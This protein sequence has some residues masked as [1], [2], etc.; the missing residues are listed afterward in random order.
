[1]M[2]AQSCLQNLLTKCQTN[3]SYFYSQPATLP[4][5]LQA[6]FVSF[7]CSRAIGMRWRVCPMAQ[8]MCSLYIAILTAVQLQIKALILYSHHYN[9]EVVLLHE[10]ILGLM[11]H[12]GC[13]RPRR[14]GYDKDG[15]RALATNDK[16][17]HVVRLIKKWSPGEYRCFSRMWQHGPN[18]PNLPILCSC[19]YAQS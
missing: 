13:R 3:R 9:W 14:Y 19:T 1:M 2:Y 8:K 16:K 6:K 18:F 12:D 17:S 10:T 4:K 7:V 5:D 15:D 11:L